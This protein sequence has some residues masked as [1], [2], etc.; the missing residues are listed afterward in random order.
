MTNDCLVQHFE[1]KYVACGATPDAVTPLVKTPKNRFEAADAA[2]LP[3]KRG[4]SA[5]DVGASDGRI[6][7]GLAAAGAK[8]DRHVLTDLSQERA[9]AAARNLRDPRFESF[10]L[11]H[12]GMTERFDAVI[13]VALIE[14]PVD[15]I[16]AMQ[17]IADAEAGR[18]RLHRYAEYREGDMSPETGSRRNSRPPHRRDEALTNY[19]G[20][21]ADL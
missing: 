13:L 17:N 5:L 8:F 15:P 1:E 21:P 10:A 16:G 20:K 9:S 11:T 3:R 4:G 6:R 19:D 2:L 7:R 12:Q 14:H 18:L